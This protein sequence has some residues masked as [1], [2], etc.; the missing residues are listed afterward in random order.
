MSFKTS[1][2]EPDKCVKSLANLLRHFCLQKE[3]PSSVL[4][5]LQMALE[6]WGEGCCYGRPQGTSS[7]TRTAQHLHDMLEKKQPLEPES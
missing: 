7:F 2:V 5:G 1:I 4:I 6:Q 3:L